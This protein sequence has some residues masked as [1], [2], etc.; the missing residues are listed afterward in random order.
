MCIQ[1]FIVVIHM[2]F[3]PQFAQS[4]TSFTHGAGAEDLLVVAVEASA[5]G[6]LITGQP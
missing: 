5:G 6:S 3:F 4:R 2:T 1:P